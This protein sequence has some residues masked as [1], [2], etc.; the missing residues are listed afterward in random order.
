MNFVK[1][2]SRVASFKIASISFWSDAESE[3]EEVKELC[4]CVERASLSYGELHAMLNSGDPEKNKKAKEILRMASEEDCGGCDGTGFMTGTVMNDH[5]I[6]WS[7]TN[8]LA[9]LEI[10]GLEPDYSGSMT[11]PEAKRAVMR[12]KNRSNV[13][14][15]ER[16][17]DVVRRHRETEDGV[18]ELNAVK[19]Y[20]KGL[21]ESDIKGKIDQF[22]SLVNSAEAEGAKNINW[23]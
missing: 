19:F 2:A 16:Q 12:A 18:T 23:G 3:G 9:L 8:A 10:L 22:E 5:G 21:S 14:R 4:F 7:N 15:F 11:V 17:D 1:I 6:T 20:S 13:K